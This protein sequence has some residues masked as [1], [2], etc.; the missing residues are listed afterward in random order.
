MKSRRG[1]VWI[2]TITYTLVALVIIGL[3]LAFARPKIQDIQDR[4][5]IEQ[6]ITMLKEID[7]IM[8]D[9]NQKGVGNKRKVE[10]SIKKGEIE[11]D[12]INNSLIFRLEGKHL[13]SQ[14]DQPYTE[15]ELNI[16]TSQ[17]GA[18]YNIS[19]RKDY[20]T[21]NLTYAGEEKNRILT[22]SPTPYVIFI[23]NNG[24]SSSNIDF[25]LQ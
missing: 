13:Y 16:L 19:V 10:L 24:G 15:G 5:I 23:S 11:I 25:E 6:S 18:F 14:L 2:E 22:E 1:Q 20:T 7:S 9:I 12:S 4:T 17:K 21:M 3:V 8:N